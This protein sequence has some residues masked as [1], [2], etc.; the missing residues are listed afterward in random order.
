MGNRDYSYNESR[1]D[2]HP[3]RRLGLLGLAMLLLTLL[4]AMLLL[5]SYAAP[6]VDPNR[7][8]PFALLGL[9]APV[10]YIA[11]FAMALYW[12]LRWKGYF[13]IPAVALVAGIGNLPLFFRPALKKQYEASQGEK[14]AFTILTYNVEG[15]LNQPAGGQP[16]MDTISSL[17]L[18]HR[19]DIVC[20]QEFQ[21]T[22]RMPRERIDL[23]LGE[24]PV[25]RAHYAIP[26]SGDPNLGWGLAVY[27]RFPIIRDRF[28]KFD[29][30]FNCM[31]MTDLVIRRGDTLR[32]LN[33]HLQTT[34]LTASDKVFMTPEQFVQ[35]DSGQKKQRL[36]SIMG[37]LSR[38]Y[39]IR[40]T[41]ADTVAKIVA[42]SPYPVIVCGDFNDTPQSYAYRT[43]RG[44][45]VDAY[46]Q[47]GHGT[48][49]TYRGLMNLF[50]ID[51]V[52]HDRRLR[53]V[54]YFSPDSDVSDHNLVSVGVSPAAP[55]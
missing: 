47:K 43:I 35:T 19:P 52:L 20:L 44:D 40:A 51:Y 49:S 55:R 5:L 1:R 18:D 24:L 29:D 3:R 26:N 14:P 36:K 45:L 9:G 17:I 15:F 13:F 8:W 39:R 33:C 34:S 2:E 4:L 42:A 41:Q 25:S 28:M 21:T 10:L 50:R 12:M 6:I 16:E 31:M 30:S 11:N 46:T 37:K 53:T 54:S 22:S 32:V 48:S 27:S 38:S 7:A 23:L